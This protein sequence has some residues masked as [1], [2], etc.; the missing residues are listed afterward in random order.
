MQ[1]VK[2]PDF[3]PFRRSLK[4]QHTG[5]VKIEPLI[6]DLQFIR[7]KKSWGYIFRFGQIEIQQPDFMRIEQAFVTTG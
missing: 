2:S 3:K 4:Y 7:N 6:K 1:V 5:V